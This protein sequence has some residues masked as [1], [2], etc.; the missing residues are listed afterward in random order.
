MLASRVLDPSYSQ[1]YVP[2]H[3]LAHALSLAAYTHTPCVDGPI[4][5][6][7]T[8]QDLLRSLFP[9]AVLYTVRLHQVYVNSGRY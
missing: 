5:V 1:T 9:M 8:C 4:H 6:E 3:A 2:L 7:F